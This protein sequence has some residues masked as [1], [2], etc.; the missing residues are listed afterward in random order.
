M[1][2]KELVTKSFKK[3]KKNLKVFH[4]KN[5]NMRINPLYNHLISLLP[6]NTSNA[7]ESYYLK[8][9]INSYKK[10]LMLL[11]KPLNQKSKSSK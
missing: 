10:L 6:I 8:I 1:N 5:Y 11:K 3:I 4:K 2:C 9:K 7:M